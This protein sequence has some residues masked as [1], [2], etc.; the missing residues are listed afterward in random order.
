MKR[1]RWPMP[2]A[3][4]IFD[5]IN[6][7]SMFTTID[8]FQG[9]WKIRIEESCKEKKTFICKYCTFSVRSNAIRTVQLRNDVPKHDGPHAAQFSKREMLNRR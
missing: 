7:S 4:E 8:Q 1:D 5:E 9:Y 3:D 2:R 6:G